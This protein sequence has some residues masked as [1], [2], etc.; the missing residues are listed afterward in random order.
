MLEVA[1]PRFVSAIKTP[2]AKAGPGCHAD[3]SSFLFSFHTNYIG[4]EPLAA[5]VFFGVRRREGAYCGPPAG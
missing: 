3:E 4:A 5:R 2:V 1:V